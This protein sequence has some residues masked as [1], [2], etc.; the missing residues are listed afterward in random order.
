MAAMNASWLIANAQRLD[1]AGTHQAAGDLWIDGGAIAAS[2][3]PAPA[4][5][6]RFD[7]AGLTLAPGL[8]DVHVHIR[9][10]GCPRAENLDSGL[11]AAAAGGFTDILMMPNTR[12]ALDVPEQLKALR[13]RAADVDGARLHLSACLTRARGGR[14]AA[15]P[16]AL[17]AAGALAFTDDGSTVPS[18]DLMEACMRRA[19]ALHRPVLDHALDPG[20]AG[21]GVMHDGPA[22][23]RLGLPGI[24]SEAEWRIVERDIE[25]CRETGCRV[26]IQ[27][28]SAAES[29][30]L[31]RRAR[32]DGL[33]VTA[34][35]TPHHLALTDED[36]PDGDA[37][38]KMNPPLRGARDRD[39]IREGLADGTLTVMATDHAP[40][41]AQ[42]KAEGLAAAPFGIVGLETAVG[43][44]YTELV[45]AGRMDAASWLAAWTSAPAALLG[46]RTP[47]LAPGGPA[48]LALLDLQAEWTV[49]PAAFV[50][51]SRNTPFAGRRLTGRAAATFRDGRLVWLHPAWAGRVS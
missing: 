4:A 26:H 34:E 43:V 31:V 27:H 30:T 1:A 25:L 5:V 33:P 16:D 6:R 49:D 17:A 29:V 22:S 10:P 47:S 3:P 14:H 39:A 15:D 21:A 18:R 20:L 51:R 45:L 11:R 35:I 13:R 36:V 48:D 32:A 38:F 46:L 44:T 2:P 40:H 23:A 9:D 8:I 42:R 41:E 7:A 12:P 37:N 28:L 24:P 50:S 19:A